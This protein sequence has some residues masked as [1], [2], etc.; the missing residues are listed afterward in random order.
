MFLSDVDQRK[1]YPTDSLFKYVAALPGMV[2]KWGR[3]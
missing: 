3:V 1:K 2:L